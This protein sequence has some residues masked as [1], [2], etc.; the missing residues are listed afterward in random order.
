MY[1]MT[2]VTRAETSKCNL[3]GGDYFYETYATAS[4]KFRL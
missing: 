3:I 2:D 4:F 1:E